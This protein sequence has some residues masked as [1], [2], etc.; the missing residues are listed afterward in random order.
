MGGNGGNGKKEMRIGVAY[1]AQGVE[2]EAFAALQGVE[3]LYPQAPTRGGGRGVS[4]IIYQARGDIS[5]V[6]VRTTLESADIGSGNI[7]QVC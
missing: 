6:R 1:V 5:P 2:R 4:G 7:Y 3:G